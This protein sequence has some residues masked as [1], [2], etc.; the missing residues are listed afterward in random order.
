MVTDL[1]GLQPRHQVPDASCDER[2]T[3]VAVEG[4]DETTAAVKRYSSFNEEGQKP[5][6]PGEV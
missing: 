4:T 2:G 3:V 5:N 1:P 6:R